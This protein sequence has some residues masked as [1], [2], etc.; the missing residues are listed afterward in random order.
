MTPDSQG[1]PSTAAG[2][3]LHGNYASKSESWVPAG[4][5]Y[6]K[7]VVHAAIP[8]IEAE[9]YARAARDMMVAHENICPLAEVWP[10]AADYL[11]SPEAKKAL[12]AALAGS[13]LAYAYG[14]QTAERIL[15]A[16]R[17]VSDPTEARDAQ[18]PHEDAVG[19][20]AEALRKTAGTVLPLSYDSEF[21]VYPEEADGIL[22]ALAESGW[23]LSHQSQK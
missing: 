19:A 16:W 23:S 9:A 12:T 7:E 21:P 10:D 17:E 11:A 15:A 13:G 20:L 3:A 14:D 5:W 4:D 6:S 18:P 22:Q 8:A 2:K 1:E